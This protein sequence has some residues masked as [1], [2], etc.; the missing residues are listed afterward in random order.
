[1]KYLSVVLLLAVFPAIGGQQGAPLAPIAL[2]TQY[3]QEP[4][5]VVLQ[6][7]QDEL[8]M[9]MAPMGLRFGWHS[10]K[11]ASGSKAAVE[12]AVLTFKGH[13]E[14]THL[15]PRSGQA[16]PLGWTHVSEGAIL[17]FADIDCDG[18]RNF[19]QMGLLA[20][21]SG[22]REELFGRALGRVVAHELYHIFANTQHHGSEG[23]GKADYSVQNLLSDDFQFG[24]KESMA[25]LTSKAH[26][27]LSIS[28]DERL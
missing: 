15:A 26:E 10:L 18:I 23:V 6:A 21:H 20:A 9:I 13:C 28:N 12:L 8:A 11:D 16:G 24:E 1:M 27:V 17:P 22:D 3:Q 14:V 7:M 19:L 2:Y 5:A 4:S 25:L